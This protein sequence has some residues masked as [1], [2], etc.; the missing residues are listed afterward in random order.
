[1]KKYHWPATFGKLENLIKRYVI[2]GTEEVISTDLVPR[3]HDF[4]SA[5]IP[6]DGQISLKKL[7]RQAVHELERKVILKVLQNCHGIESR[8]LVPSASS[9]RRCSIRFATQVCLLTVL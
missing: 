9:Y 5:E 1:L 8:R 6:L 7:T 3:D 2:L 4:F